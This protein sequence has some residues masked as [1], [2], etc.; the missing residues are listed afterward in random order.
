[1]DTTGMI[2]ITG[3]DMR[4]LVKAAYDLSRPQGMGML[5]FQPGQMQDE[6]AD[7]LLAGAFRPTGYNALYLD[8]VKGRAV[9]LNVYRDVENGNLYVYRDWYD[10]SPTDMN[11]LMAAIGKVVPPP[12]V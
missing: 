2:D 3:C 8:Y 11:L 1:M 12:G 10:H 9:K 6:D 5:H 4:A 7:L